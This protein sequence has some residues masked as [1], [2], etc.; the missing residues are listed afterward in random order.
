MKDL[1]N[2]IFVYQCLHC[3]HIELLRY[4]QYEPTCNRHTWIVLAKE[5]PDGCLAVWNTKPH[6][7]RP[8]AKIQIVNPRETITTTS[9][10]VPPYTLVSLFN[11]TESRLKSYHVYNP[12]GTL[13]AVEERRA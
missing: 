8:Y 1:T 12:E 5:V 10:I 4:L 11:A 2:S 6:T 13:P 7:Y 3:H 9:F